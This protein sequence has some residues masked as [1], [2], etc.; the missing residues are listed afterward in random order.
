MSERLFNCNQLHR[1]EKSV[2]V[3]ALLIRQ[4][5]GSSEWQILVSET[6]VSQLLNFIL[7]QMRYFGHFIK[8]TFDDSNKI[9]FK[10]L[11]T[12]TKVN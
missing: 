3:D 7:T 6:H 4:E 12:I 8:H 2:F 10:S 1:F 11:T 9:F 5:S